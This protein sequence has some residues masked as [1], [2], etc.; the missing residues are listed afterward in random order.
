MGG[1]I[2]VLSRL[3]GRRRYPMDEVPSSI[4]ERPSLVTRKDVLTGDMKDREELPS[5]TPGARVPDPPPAPVKPLTARAPGEASVA[6]P[7]H[8]LPDI[9]FIE[10]ADWAP[11]LGWPGVPF[12]DQPDSTIVS[13]DKLIALSPKLA[14]PSALPAPTNIN[15]YAEVP[16]LSPEQKLRGQSVSYDRYAKSRD[17]LPSE[18]EY[19]ATHKRRGVGGRILSGLEG[20]LQM[21]INSGGNPLAAIAGVGTGA[22][23]PDTVTRTRYNMRVRPQA[24][25]EQER[26]LGLANREFGYENQ[27]ED[28]ERTNRQLD[29]LDARNKDAA[30][31]AR[32]ELVIKEQQVAINA[33]K[34]KA[35]M[36][37]LDDKARTARTRQLIELNKQGSLSESDRAQLGA[38]LNLD[39]P[40]HQAY[41][42]GQYQ[43]TID[44]NGEMYLINQQ[45]GASI[46]VLDAQ[47]K[48][49]TSFKVT[50]EENKKVLAEDDDTTRRKIA[51]TQEQGRNDRFYRR[52]TGKARPSETA[53]VYGSAK[54][55]ASSL[56]RQQMEEDEANYQKVAP[57]LS[58]TAR[59]TL[60]DAF[61][62]QYGRRP[63]QSTAWG[64]Q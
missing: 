50:Q 33:D 56:H 45:G 25:A 54:K 11:T 21:F 16:E 46:P 38:A 55:V 52:Q 43:L 6:A 30:E 17:Q 1:I 27:M 62:R 9:P 29:I 7:V 42:K 35:Y 32:Q 15:L 44:H 47:G 63:R 24:I 59:K 18:D 34:A 41:I 31:I 12:V 61:E 4:N 10:S 13:R 14:P 2:S 40:V 5:D 58:E 49:M 8:E 57:K 23:S 51:E 22:I 53:Q 36:Q 26:L 20:G 19:L 37:S 64:K 39:G 28:N 48:R 3:S 60:E